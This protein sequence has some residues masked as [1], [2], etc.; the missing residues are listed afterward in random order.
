[1]LIV[2]LAHSNLH[3]NCGTKERYICNMRSVFQ[4]VAL[5][6]MHV[7]SQNW[8]SLPKIPDGMGSFWKIIL[9]GKAIRVYRRMIHGLRSLPSQ[10]KRN[11][12][13]LAQPSP[14]LHAAVPG[15]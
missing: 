7:P 10:C 13:G 8:H 6:A 15:N 9:S 11:R 12:F 14:L 1:M 3:D 4:I 5:G 2:D